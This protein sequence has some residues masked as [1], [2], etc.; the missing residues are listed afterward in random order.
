MKEGNRRAVNVEDKERE[1][2]GKDE[3]EAERRK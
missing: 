1:K 3:N 2:R